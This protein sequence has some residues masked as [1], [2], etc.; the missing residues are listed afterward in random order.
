MYA[1]VQMANGNWLP[2]PFL[3]DTGA[4]RTVL[5]A[6]VFRALGVAPEGDESSN[7]FGVGGSAESVIVTTK[8]RL[9]RET[10]APVHF[11][12]QFAA[13]T[14]PVSIDM[15][16]FG[17]DILNLF[18]VIIDRPQDVVCLIGQKHRYEIVETQK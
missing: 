4:D 17:R 10:G 9:T 14:D 5:S 15:S 16:V 2:I 8:I 3:V 6:D 13:F 12:G 11:G 1:N 7:L 18:A